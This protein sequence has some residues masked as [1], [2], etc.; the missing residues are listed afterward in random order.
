MRRIEMTEVITREE[1]IIIDD[2]FVL[3]VELNDTESFKMYLR[4]NDYFEFLN[5]DE[6]KEY[7]ESLMEYHKIKD[8]DLEELTWFAMNN[9][10]LSFN[11]DPSRIEIVLAAEFFNNYDCQTSADD[12]NDNECYT[13]AV[14]NL[15]K[16]CVD[17]DE[18]INEFNN[19]YTAS[20]FTAFCV[21]TLE[22]YKKIVE[23]AALKRDLFI[24]IK[25]G[26]QYGFF[27]SFN[28][29]G[30]IFEARFKKDFRRL[31]KVDEFDFI[32]V[33]PEFC[34]KEYSLM[35]VYGTTSFIKG[36]E[37]VIE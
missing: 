12:I 7:V 29:S 2:P 37:I 20:I 18:F 34:M 5:F 14:Y 31:M 22:K 16:K 19:A 32:Y 6:V 13:G 10:R 15:V 35:D 9:A 17:R 26:T 1:K 28:G 30:S 24:T 4:D 27:S 8:Y 23:L 11:P 3:N 36:G 33:G 21:T 25:E